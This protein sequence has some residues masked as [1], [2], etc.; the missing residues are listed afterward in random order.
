MMTLPHPAARVL[1]RA[2]HRALWFAPR[3][4]VA[5]LLALTLTGCRSIANAGSTAQVRVIDVSPDAPA[6]DIVPVPG[7]VPGPVPASP[8]A[9]ASSSAALYNIGFGTVSSY[10]QLAPGAWTHSAY[11][12]GTQ[13]QIALV[14]GSLAAGA[15]YTVLTGDVSA[16]LQMTLL[17]D[18]STAAPPGLVSLRF[19]GQS[20]RASA[21]DLYLVP[22]GASLADGLAPAAAS[23]SFGSN[24]G[25][26]NLP[27]GTY[28]LVAMPAGA[29]PAVATPLFTG[30]QTVYPAGSARTILLIDAPSAMRTLS[31]AFAANPAVP[32]QF[33]TAAD[34]DPPPS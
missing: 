9:S 31:G 4:G 2:S 25:Y 14:R 12:A 17:R 30:S 3:L 10:M 21:V 7:P 18:Q 22:S 29:S 6:L 15:Q 1:R 34:Y 16:G 24:T 5:A 19:L 27:A 11:L 23:L 33:I 26:R 28:S 32:L 20:T 13:Q 8:S